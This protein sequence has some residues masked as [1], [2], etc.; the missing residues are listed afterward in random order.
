LGGFA[1]L[2]DMVCIG[3]MFPSYSDA[4]DTKEKRLWRMSF[5]GF[6]IAGFREEE[7]AVFA[8]HGWPNERYTS[9]R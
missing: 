4:K 9:I 8:I 3:K 7:A 5:H 2:K 6:L 1:L